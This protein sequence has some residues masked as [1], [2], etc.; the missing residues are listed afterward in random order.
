MAGLAVANAFTVESFFKGSKHN[1]A[2]SIQNGIP[3]TMHMGTTP[4]DEPDGLK[5]SVAVNYGDI[6]RYL[7][8][9]PSLY[10]FF[11]Y[12][13][14]LNL[15]IDISLDSSNT[16]SDSWFVMPSDIKRYAQRNYVLMSQVIYEIPFSSE[17]DNKDF[18][19]IVIK[20][21]PGAVTFNPGRESLSLDKKTIGY[22]NSAFN[23]IAEECVEE[24]NKTLPL[25][26]SD[27]ELLK[28]YNSTIK[29][30]PRKLS[31]NINVEVF[32]SKESKLLFASSYYYTGTSFEYVNQTSAFDQHTN[33]MLNINYKTSYYKSSKKLVDAGPQ[34]SHS[35]YFSPHVIV[36]VKTNYKSQL[37][38]LHEQQR[39]FTWQKTKNADLDEAVAT[40]KSFLEALGIP[41]KLASDLLKDIP[42]I[43]KKTAPREGLHSYPFT[44]VTAER[45]EKFSEQQSKA[46][47]YLYLKLNKTTPV[48]ND[49]VNSFSSYQQV[50]KI[51]QNIVYMPPV[52]GVPKKYQEYVENLDNWVDYETFIK[53]KVKSHTFKASVDVRFPFIPREVLNHNNILLYPQKVQN[54]Y[55]SYEKFSEYTKDKKYIADPDVEL[56]LKALGGTFESLPMDV[57]KITD[58][59]KKDF[60]LTSKLLF[61]L[62]YKYNDDLNFCIDLAK[63]EDYHATHSTGQ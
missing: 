50:Y 39:L 11:D 41:Y 7:Q 19:N 36:D 42:V 54:F 4:T 23:K 37:N 62:R 16:L 44:G 49:K 1:Y 22:L 6:S 43:D 60:P 27:Y 24:I 8:R 15:D 2:I 48:L 17:V 40:A 21:P 33:N 10:K 14:N 58:A 5:L 30:L 12:K 29:S 53:D 59:F 38:R 13:P 61:N 46:K 57:Q 31:K 47:T 32:M 26:D 51:L 28:F 55:R 25:M 20:A 9:A 34:H 45:V 52:R 35:F 56:F 3:V 63:L 18:V